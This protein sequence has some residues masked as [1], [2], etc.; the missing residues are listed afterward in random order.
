M[1]PSNYEEWR[2]CI[3]EKC[4]IPL[5][6]S[7]VKA[8]LSTLKNDSSEETAKFRKRYGDPYWKKVLEWFEKA[9]QDATA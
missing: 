6:Q 2:Y 1:I 3:E 9:L 4:G 7:F 8:R 5:T